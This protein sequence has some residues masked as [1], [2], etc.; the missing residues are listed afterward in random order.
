MAAKSGGYLSPSGNFQPNKYTSQGLPA[1]GPYYQ[2]YGEQPGYI[3][4]PYLDRYRPDPK[5]A[6]NYYESA[7][8]AEGEKS[9]PSTA[10]QLGTLAGGAALTAVGT[11][12]GKDGNLL[13][14]QLWGDGK[15]PTGINNTNSGTNTNVGQNTNVQNTGLIPT[16][17]Q[18]TRAPIDTTSLGDQNYSLE[19]A[20]VGELEYNGEPIS[21][22]AKPINYGAYAQ[23]AA[24]ALQGYQAY[25]DYQDKDYVGAGLNT[26]GAAANIGSAAGSST[27]GQAVPYVNAALTGYNVYQ[28]LNNKD[29][30]ARTRGYQAVHETGM[31]VANAASFGL[32]GLGDAAIQKWAPGFYKNHMNREMKYNP[33]VKGVGRLISGKDQ[34]QFIRDQGR[35]YLKENK[36]LDENYMGTL[37]DGSK[38]DFGKDGKGLGKIDYKDPVTGEVIARADLLA[39]AEGYTGKAREAMAMLYT[40]AAMSNAKGDLR[41]AESNIAHFMKQRNMTSAD[42]QKKLDED[43]KNNLLSEDRYKVY[44]GTNQNFTTNNVDKVGLVNNQKPNQGSPGMRPGKTWDGSRY[45]DNKKSNNTKA[46][47]VFNQLNQGA[48]AI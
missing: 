45:V 23:G 46:D 4:D 32:A 29:V 3:Y 9:P 2:Y 39:A 1:P 25:Q 35:K 43:Y 34:Y 24:G 12:V 10:A 40:N 15:A 31:G 42:I 17:N 19:D 37:A 11:S 28:G 22:G 33:I 48:G 36:I 13:G 7:G 47:R 6:Q 8:L 41:K 16:N 14:Y 27:A 38:F 44:T 20:G 18:G 30:D 21:Q 5:A 26:A